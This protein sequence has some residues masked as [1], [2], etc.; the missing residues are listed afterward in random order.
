MDKWLNHP[1][2]LKVI[3][4]V[5]ALLLWAVVHF[6]PEA[7]AT[8]TSTVDTKEFEALQV[9]AV[10]YD[11]TLH[12]LRLLEPS[13]VRIM[14]RGSR[15]DLLSASQ[16]EYKVS[17]DL[18]D[19][20]DGEHILPLKVEL[21]NRIQL[22]ELSPARVT[23]ILE[24]MRTK[25]F[26]V[27]INTIGKPANDYKVGAP[28]VKPNSRAFVTL[29]ED[30][31]DQVGRVG[32]VIDVENE[33]N[34]VNEKR[35]KLMAYDKAGQEMP[36]AVVDPET[37]EV[38]VPITKPF[39]HLPLRI[40]LAGKL[41]NGLSLVAVRSETENVTAYGPQVEL[42]KYDHF[43]N[44]SV[45]L[46]SIRGSG[47]VSV[48]LKPMDGLASVNPS[49]IDVD[50][51][52]APSETRTLPQ[53]PI[54]V[55]GLSGGLDARFLTPEAGRLDI[56]VRGAPSLLAEL[57]ARDIQVMVDV[58]GLAPGE[59]EVPIEVQ[60]PRFIEIGSNN[61]LTARVQ[62]IDSNE[63]SIQQPEQEP[64]PGA[65]SEDVPEESVQNTP[66][67]SADASDAP[68]GES[69]GNAEA[70]TSP[71]TVNNNASNKVE[72]QPPEPMD[73]NDRT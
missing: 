38:E 22:V 70:D 33:E 72:E 68:A 67:T 29:P 35:V 45:N 23:V 44:V 32:A 12:D 36:D 10:G 47:T 6:D 60:L 50:I 65:M 57:V 63:T 7:P 26:D 54:A 51:E 73:G 69:S 19:I 43:D 66:S 28:I 31:M 58:N 42:D 15:S 1:T 2:I 17:V 62:I 25:E 48:D 34:T 14:V 16:D 39:K 11:E 71:P 3:S 56:Q 21:P 20:P 24:P 37:V 27:S 64:E 49:K 46:S 18:T 55:T 5:L 59:H 13:V 41:P 9:R 8:I 40:G 4:V 61:E 52:V 53:I 30:L